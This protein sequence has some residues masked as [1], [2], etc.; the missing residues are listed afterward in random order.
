MNLREITVGRSR[1]CDIYLDPRCKYASSMHGTF[2]YDGFKL[3]YRDTST[4]G[5]LVNNVNVHRRA[6]PVNHGDIIMIAG[7]YPLNW[8]QIDSFFPPGLPNPA[9]SPVLGTMISS[10]EQNA[11]PI[12]PD[13]N[14]WNWG[15]FFLT[16]IWG[17]GNGCWWLFLIYLFIVLCAVIPFVNIIAGIMSIALAVICG[18]KGN[19]WAWSNK[20]WGS[21]QE[22]HDSQHTWA[23]AG[24]CVFL[25]GVMVSFLSAFIVFSHI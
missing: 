22:F 18:A 17:I 14:K 15:A 19:E 5:T 16:G 25:V 12:P 13:L 4:N 24:L 6:V 11:I 7:N 1:N 23:K 10:P 2:Y 20:N 3:M 9:P 21:I 8:N